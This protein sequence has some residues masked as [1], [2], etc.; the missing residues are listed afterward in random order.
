VRLNRTLKIALAAVVWSGVGYAEPP[1][2]A[3]LDGWYLT[4]GPVGAA[5]RVADQWWSAF[6][7]ELSVVRVAEHA[8]PAALGLAGGGVSYAGRRGG[9]LWLEAEIGVARPLP[10]G[11]GVGLAAEVDP[12]EPP[13]LGVEATLWA[14]GGLVPYVRVGTVKTTG[15]FVEAGAMI[16]VPVRF[17][18]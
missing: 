14:Y 2:P 1:T 11:L 13:R 6:G 9:R 7:L 15:T 3:D 16:K 8:L 12:V 10:I 17:L 4:I 18:Y 5:S